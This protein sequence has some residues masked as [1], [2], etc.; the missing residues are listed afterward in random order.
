[1]Q[2]LGRVRVIGND[3]KMREFVISEKS[4]LDVIG[5]RR[6]LKLA[7]CSMQAA[8]CEPNTPPF[9]TRSPPPRIH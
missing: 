7:Q 9:C 1:M 3:Q 5:S 8:M 2:V 6:I 4:R